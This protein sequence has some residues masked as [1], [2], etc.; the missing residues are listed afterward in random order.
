MKAQANV[1]LH[2]R[3]D[4]EVRDAITGELK[5]TAQAENIVLDAMWTRLC[6]GSAYFVNIHFGTG[7]G[8][9]APTRTSLFTHLGTKTA[10]DDTLVKAIPNSSWK[11]KIVLN[12]EEYVGAT[13]SEVG[14]AFGA[15]ASNLVTHA[16]LEDSEGNPITITK[17][18]TDVITIYA[19]VFVTFGTP[20]NDVRFSNMPSGNTLVN[21][22]IGGA[23]FP[24]GAFAVGE[25]DSTAELPVAH[26]LSL[27]ITGVTSSA[28]W[29]ADTA[30]KKRSTNV[31]RFGTTVG[32]GHLAEFGYNSVFRSKLPSDGI[33]SGQAYTA[34]AIGTGDG[35]NKKFIL[36]SRNVRLSSVVAK[37]D[38]VI[39]TDRSVNAITSNAQTLLNRKILG[40][41]GGG[42]PIGYSSNFNVSPDGKAIFHYD[43]AVHKI[44]VFNYDEIKKAISLRGIISLAASYLTAKIK[45]SDN[46]DVVLAQNNIFKWNGSEY[47]EAP[48][49]G[50][51]TSGITIMNISEDGNTLIVGHDTANAPVVRL[52]NWNETTSEWDALPTVT[53][54]PSS[55]AKQVFTN[56]GGTAIA[57]SC[58]NTTKYVADRIDTTWTH[59]AALP[60][61]GGQAHELKLANNTNTFIALPLE[62]ES[63]KVL[64]WNGSVW[65][66]R[67][68]APT[69]G[70]YSPVCFH[71][72]K[73]A[74]ILIL[75]TNGNL[76]AYYYDGTAYQ[77]FTVPSGVLD[78]NGSAYGIL[79]DASIAHIPYYSTDIL[80]IDAKIIECEI[81][82][83]TAPAAGVA[84]TADYTVDGV[85]KTDQYVIDVGFSIQFGEPV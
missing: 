34:V 33:F 78:A 7:T 22:L 70:G 29:S 28:T 64:D 68:G 35:S 82:F 50:L 30:N 41:H 25:S 36:P 12:P 32:N 17:T 83:D 9:L 40:P 56:N 8:T 72:N 45:S 51:Y 43:Y 84:I 52:Y 10:V 15:T 16:M 57:Y 39:N 46:G 73:D 61:I 31:M 27:P 75:K 74:T 71:S 11:R 18:D 19:T 65:T 76:I 24:S 80:S 37:K 63:S 42:T 60:Y 4:I 21:Y 13:L 55:N 54:L 14:I 5:Q 77:A 69:T 3:F 79:S 26:V 85:H 23:A 48:K 49:T 58:A 20:S 2:N 1:N 62:N 44:R 59:R 47:V 53:G 67:A 6:G 81:E 38:S 66:A